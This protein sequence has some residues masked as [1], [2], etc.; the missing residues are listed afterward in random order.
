MLTGGA[1]LLWLSKTSAFTVL[2]PTSGEATEL[3]PPPRDVRAADSRGFVG[4][5]LPS[6]S[7][8]VTAE[9]QGRIEVIRVRLGETVTR[10]QVLAVIASPTLTAL[11]IEMAK[12]ELSAAEVDSRKLG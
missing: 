9:L 6:E 2:T 12:A 5:V 4:V 11:D 7:V 8:D 1:G 3:R 10:E